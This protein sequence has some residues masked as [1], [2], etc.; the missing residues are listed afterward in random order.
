MA[1]G[2]LRRIGLWIREKHPR[3]SNRATPHPGPGISGYGSALRQAGKR[4]PVFQPQLKQ[5]GEEMD[6]RQ[7][8]RE[9]QLPSTGWEM[10]LN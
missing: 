5:V 2:S 8:P 4:Q 10:D 6:V 1:S 7:D 3:G 9:A